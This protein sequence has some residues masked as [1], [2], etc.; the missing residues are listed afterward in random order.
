MPR[1]TALDQVNEPNDRAVDAG[2]MLRII[3]KT[4]EGLVTPLGKQLEHERS[5]ADRAERLVEE[6]RG[7][8]AENSSGSRHY[9]PR[10]PMR[11]R[12]SGSP[13]AR[14]PHCGPRSIAGGAWAG[15]DEC[16]AAASD[17]V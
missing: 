7:R 2:D 9:T 4:M 15:C 17:R 11:S 12:P 16:S 3:R 5:R 10:S 1:A 13:P 8:V 6:E 14:L